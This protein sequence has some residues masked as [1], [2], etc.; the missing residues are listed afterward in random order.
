MPSKCRFTFP[1]AVGGL[2]KRITR[3]FPQ[4]CEGCGVRIED[5]VV[6]DTTGLYRDDDEE[7][8]RSGIHVQIA[9]YWLESEVE[10]SFESPFLKQTL[11]STAR[12]CAYI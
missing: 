8:V 10:A 6:D 12:L 9:R 11:P 1:Y 5:A 3:C 2:K 7:A 4:T